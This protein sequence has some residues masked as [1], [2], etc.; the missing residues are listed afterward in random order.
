MASEGRWWAGETE[1]AADERGGEGPLAAGSELQGF[2]GGRGVE[3]QKTGR[4]R[5]GVEPPRARVQAA[6]RR[7][8]G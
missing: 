4:L 2:M 8:G 7:L 1:R 6:L 3:K 5:G